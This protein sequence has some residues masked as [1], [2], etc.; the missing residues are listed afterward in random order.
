MTNEMFPLDHAPLIRV[1]HR[2]LKPPLCCMDE[3]A[4]YVL[5]SRAAS[6][7]AAGSFRASWGARMK[8]QSM[9]YVSVMEISNW[10]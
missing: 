9:F 8:P 10:R 3:Q 7:D 1:H 4:V 5:N 6:A 2:Q